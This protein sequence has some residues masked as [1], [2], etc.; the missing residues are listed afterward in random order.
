M[1]NSNSLK[2]TKTQKE[3]SEEFTPKY[4][5]DP[6]SIQKK[7]WD[8]TLLIMLIYTATYSPYRTAFISEDPSSILLA[9]E[10][11]MDAVFIVDIFLNFITPYEKYDH[12]FEFDHKKIALYYLGGGSFF[13]DL[14]A[15]FPW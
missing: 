11:V 8:L 5:L 13:I 10:K 14:L 15:A 9:F 4:I 6:L 7:M 2:D 1:L 12:T 3:N